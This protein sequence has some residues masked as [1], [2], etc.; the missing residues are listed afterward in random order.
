MAGRD[1]MASGGRDLIAASKPKQ[2][3]MLGPLQ[4][5]LSGESRQTR[6]TRELPEMHRSGLLHG[7]DKGTA[8]AIT[9]AIMTATDPNEIAQIV[10]QNFPNVGVTYNKD[11]EGNVYPVLV[12][13]ETGAATVINRPGMSAFDALQTIGI[14]AALF[15]ANRAATMVGAGVKSAVGESALQAT[16]A[17]SGGEFNEGEVLLSAG[18]G[19]AGQGVENLVS[20]GS[21]LARGDAAGTAGEKTVRAGD[22]AG[23]RVMSSDVSPPDT[24]MGKALQQA[25]ESV[26]LV[27][28]AG[29]RRAQQAE[30]ES[31]VNEVISRYADFSYDAIVSSL[32]ESRNRVKQA[33][34][35]VL[36]STGRQL[37]GVGNV[38]LDA[39]Q[40]AIQSATQALNKPG[41]IRSDSAMKDLQTLME[42]LQTPQTFTSLKENRTAFREL[43]QGLDK[44]ERSQLPSRAK[45]L[46]ESVRAGMTADME[47]F[48]KQN[49]SPEQFTKWQRANRTWAQHADTM[50]RTKIKGILDNGALRPEQVE[51]L[52]LSQKP[53]EVKLLYDN[54]TPQGRRHARGAIVQKVVT[55]LS[56]RQHGITPN[57]FAT[58]L[59][60]YDQHID[61]FFKGAERDRLR[62]LQRVLEATTRAQDAAA[63][64]MTGRQLIPWLTGGAVGAEAVATGGLPVLSGVVL[65]STA[66][67]SRMYESRSVR[68]ALLR[69]G[70]IP[71]E[72]DAFDRAL[73][74][75]MT[76]L[77]S[78]AQAI[79]EA[80]PPQ[81]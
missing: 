66:G 20:G 59:K 57:S 55:N 24:F 34:G 25:G 5:L 56:R 29:A 28:T 63:N 42:A 35:N 53:S 1:L 77:T 26:P 11:G 69:L 19:A 58:E 17:A 68:D 61:I 40:K 36:E 9:P 38:P 74:D 4:N 78:A 10:T 14:G 32:K 64:P 71:R 33:A 31:A 23:I 67:L 16:Q 70:S 39:T 43:M 8:A 72:S 46:L 27:G 62:G 44:A 76:A 48:A 21:R 37:D 47:S 52:L 51:T 45:D 41:V 81:E 80:P 60:K 54:L 7:E 50:K 6:Q 79:A 3:S 15:P 73:R 18:I 2:A 13:N 30:R 12:N 49:L 65:G 75:A 22:E